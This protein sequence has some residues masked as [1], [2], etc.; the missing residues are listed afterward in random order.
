MSLGA[1]RRREATVEIVV[2]LVV[3]VWL[4][5]DFGIAAA[6]PACSVSDGG[7]LGQVVGR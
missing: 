4:V 3:V 7:D 6:A 1:R 5:R 2:G